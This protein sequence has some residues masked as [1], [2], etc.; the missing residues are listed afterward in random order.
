MALQQITQEDIAGWNSLGAIADCFKKRGLKPRENLGEENELVLQLTDTEFIVVVEAGPG[1]SATDFKPD[2]RNRRTNLVATNDYEEFTFLTRIRSWEGQQHGRIKHQ[3]LSFTKEQMTSESGEKNTVLQKLNSIEYGSADAIQDTLYDTKQVVKEFYQQFEELRTNLVQEVA[4][5]P[6][7]RGDAKQRYVQVLLDRMIFL[8]F[9][10]EKRLLDRNIEYLHEKHDAIVDEGGD[11]YDEF[12]H[13][14]FFEMLAEGKQD[15][16][17]GSLPYLNG[18]LFSKNPVEEEFEDARLGESS[19]QTNEYFGDILDFLSD[20]NWNVDER[21]DVVD[22]KNLSPEILGHIFEQTVNQKEMGAY[23]TPE[24]ITGFMA[25]ETVHPYLLDQLN[26][27]TDA[28]YEEID[29]VFGF[30][31]MDADAG[32]EALADG[33]AVTAQVPTEDIQTRHVETLYHDILT[34]MRVLDP[35]VGSGAFLLASQEVL[36]D[37]YIQCIEFFQQLVDEGK[38][39]EL[40]NRTRDVLD[41]IQDG[42]GSPSLYAKRSIIL[43]NLYG[44]D[45]DDG[46]VE[47]CKLRL[48]LSMVA[49]IE[50][51]P[52]EVEPLPNIDFNIRQ[53][54]S[55]IGFTELVEIDQDGNAPLTNYGIGDEESVRQMFDDV[56]EAIERHRSSSSARE[57]TNARNMAESHIRSHSESLDEKILNEFRDAGAEDVTLEDV[58]EFDPFHWIIEFAPVYADGGFDVLI[59]NPPWDQLRASRDDYFSKFDE[60]FRSRMPSDKDET[61]DQLLSGPQIKRGWEEL[62]ENI[63]KQMR[64]FTDGSEY[65]LQKPTIDGRKDPNE[66]NLAALF[67]ERVYDLVGKEGYVAQV[68]PGVIFS[69]SFSKDL[70][71]KMLD[72]SEITNLIGFENKGIFPSIDD[73]YQFAVVTFCNRGETETLRGVFNQRDVGILTN[74]GEHGIEIPK[75]VLAQYSAKARI[76]PNLTSQQQVSVLKSIILHPQL[77]EELEGVWNVTPHRELDRSRASDRFVEEEKEGDYPVYGG[78]NIHQFAYDDEVDGGAS[79]PELWSVEEDKQDQSAKYRVRERS[80][81]SGSLKKSIYKTFGG[82]STS[83]SQKG[84]VNDLLEESRGKPLSIE[85]VLPDFTEYRVVYRDISNSTNERTMIAA[86]IPKGVVCVHTIQTL[87]PYTLSPEEEDLTEIPLHSVYNRSY[88][89]R[90]LFVITGLLNSL[91]FDYLMRTKV[92][93]HIVRFKL[94][95]SQVPR[96]NSG[97]N[98]FHYIAE[99]AARL[100]CYG[101]EFAEMRERLDGIEPA[102]DRSKRRELQAEIDAA[103]FHAYGLER[104]DVEFVLDDFHRVSNPRIMTEEY[105]DMVFEKFDTLAKEGPHK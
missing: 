28:K 77:G 51:E 45:I 12:Y 82:S 47:I 58:R 81:N 32:V 94:E 40:E 70:R 78:R 24:E 25:R 29:D 10:Q 99:R 88:T 59:G 73:R 52:S 83:K 44:V 57:A 84:F 72:E 62:Q 98:W 7:D 86:V 6:N 79:P 26:E 3:K 100:N 90:E 20:W 92:D 14:L 21:L 93:T 19:E 66:N 102:T 91:P 5:I 46:A 103:A 76:F 17:F 89:D 18:G 80:F 48:W 8:Y 60:Q 75:E 34:E 36:L 30:S 38:G 87:S 27:A 55:L 11:V 69:G 63:E 96:L 42:R 35:A 105:F 39:W 43:N 104:R 95:E 50:D 13:P 9:I 74:I 22:P 71:M 37:I 61:Q 97:D 64:Y 53:G 33:G 56:I 41:T 67:L 49:D 16:D 68:L 1:E 4:N 85:D 54:N 23:Y 15:P 65:Q 2:N 31:S 101:E